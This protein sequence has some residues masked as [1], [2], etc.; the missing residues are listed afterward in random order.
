MKDSIKANLI[1]FFIVAIVAFGV[2]S[3]FAKLTITEDTDSYKLI[4]IENNSFKPNYIDEVP[5]IIETTNTTNTTNATNSTYSDI[6]YNN[7][8]DN[9]NNYN[10]TNDND[11]NDYSDNAYDNVVTYEYVEYW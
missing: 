3:S 4:S 9:S 6:E 7:Y 10:Y 8:T 1:I 5:T 2:S 11:Y